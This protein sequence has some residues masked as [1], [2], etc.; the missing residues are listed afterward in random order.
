VL[1]LVALPFAAAAYVAAALLAILGF[2]G[3]IMMLAVV[4]ALLIQDGGVLKGTP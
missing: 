1:S 4:L 2:G 3:T